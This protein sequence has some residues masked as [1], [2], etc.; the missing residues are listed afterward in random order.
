MASPYKNEL[1]GKKFPP[2]LFLCFLF[3]FCF[4][5]VFFLFF[6]ICFFFF[7]F[8]F[9]CFYITLEKSGDFK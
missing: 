8:F 3:F 2:D 1:G 4:F 5:F 7:F 9:I 6:F